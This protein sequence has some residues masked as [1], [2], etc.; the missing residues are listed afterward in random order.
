MPDFPQAA[1]LNHVCKG[2]LSVACLIQS[3]PILPIIKN[4]KVGADIFHQYCIQ[5]FTVEDQCD[6]EKVTDKAPRKFSLGVFENVLVILS[7]TKHFD[8]LIKPGNDHSLTRL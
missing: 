4:I 8:V 3:A 6:C 1:L 7:N 2:C 5:K